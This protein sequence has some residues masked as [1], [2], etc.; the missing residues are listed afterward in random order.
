MLNHIKSKRNMR[1]LALSDSGVSVAEIAE[2]IHRGVNT[3]YNVLSIYRPSRSLT[4]RP[5]AIKS[6]TVRILRARYP[7]VGY[8]TD[9][10][11][12]PAARVENSAPLKENPTGR[13]LS[14]IRREGA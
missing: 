14:E 4:R 9:A 6:R 10:R 13:G 7:S 1:I 3:V 12:E 8:R 5:E 2:Q 11:Y